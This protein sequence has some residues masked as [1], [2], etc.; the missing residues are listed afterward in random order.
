MSML[1]ASLLLSL[2][3]QGLKYCITAIYEARKL[4]RPNIRDKEGTRAYLENLLRWIAYFQSWFFSDMAIPAYVLGVLLELVQPGEKW[5]AFYNA[6]IH[7]FN[8]RT[9]FPPRRTPEI[10]EPVE[11]Q[12]LIRKLCLRIRRVP[13]Y[14]DDRVI[15]EPGETETV[16]EYLVVARYL[17]CHPVILDRVR[18]S[19]Q[20]TT[21]QRS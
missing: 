19:Y 10:V 6:I 21:N 15:P 18:R 4:Q 14:M 11:R 7:D 2:M 12:R 9:E 3:V 1:L 13:E 17:L 5:D 16:E 20:S 8:V